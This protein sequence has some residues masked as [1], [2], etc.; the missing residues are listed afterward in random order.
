MPAS[1]AVD[2]SADFRVAHAGA[3]HFRNAQVAVIG[4]EGIALRRQLASAA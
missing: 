1:L 4:E 2:Q 3:D